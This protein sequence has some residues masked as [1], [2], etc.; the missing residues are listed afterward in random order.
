MMRMRGRRGLAVL[1]GL[2]LMAG[3]GDPELAELSGPEACKALGG[4]FIGD[5]GDGSVHR[6]GCPGGEEYLGPVR[7][8]I[9]GGICC[10]AKR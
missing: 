10:R 5:P 9:E 2:L 6:E 7:F 8:G 4:H 1:A 3:C